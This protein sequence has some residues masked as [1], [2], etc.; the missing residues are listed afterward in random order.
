[1]WRGSIDST[2]SPEYYKWTQWFFLKLW[3]CGYVAQKDGLV[4]WDPVDKTVLANEQVDQEGR[5]WR[6]G[7]V[8]EKRKL[9]QWYVLTTRMEE[10]LLQGLGTLKHWPSKVKTAQDRWIGKSKGAEFR[11]RLQGRS[12]P[13]SVFTTH[14]ET[15]MGVSFLGLS[16]SHPL[17][18]ELSEKSSSLQQFVFVTCWFHD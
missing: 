16:P 1:M 12:E 3:E 18:L 4:N 13:L 17:T 11:F 10:E 9:R 5:S 15:L 7:A 8:V 2:S 6:S 14:P